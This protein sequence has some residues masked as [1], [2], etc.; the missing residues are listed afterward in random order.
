MYA[1]L[2]Q[3]AV[4]YCSTLRKRYKQLLLAHEKIF[5]V[6]NIAKV[7]TYLISADKT[8]LYTTFKKN[9]K[10]SINHFD[11]FSVGLFE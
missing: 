9:Y 7:L 5:V 3:S 2:T 4:A 6:H 11:T 1:A 8:I 10:P